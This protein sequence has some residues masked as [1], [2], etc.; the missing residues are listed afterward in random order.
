M[1]AGSGTHPAASGA[2]S[3]RAPW[4]CSVLFVLAAHVA[5]TSAQAKTFTILTGEWSPY[6]SERLEGGGPLARLVA[7]A[8][9][10]GGHSAAFVFLPWARA[11]A[12]VKNGQALA[13]FPWAPTRRFTETCHV[14]EPL[15]GQRMVFFSLKER[16]P[17]WDYTG[18]E[19][20][21]ELRVGGS[22]GYAYV[23]IFAQEGVAV[24][25]GPDPERSF[26]KLFAGRV[27]LVPENEVVG[28]SILKRDFAAQADQVASSRTPLFTMN[29]H[30]M[31]A[32]SDPD[33]RELQEAFDAGLRTL[34]ASGRYR[35]ILRQGD[36]LPGDK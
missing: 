8:L 19:S 23:D 28:W 13:T 4:I 21:Q 3:A 34:K 9:E 10:A 26:M 7:E 20:L 6:V 15:I 24:D 22:L 31:I 17:G 30:L 29:L 2:R 14:S 5:A 35:E 25:Y 1:A 32:K 12:S 16:L 11:E 36:L 27:D 18:P 33:A